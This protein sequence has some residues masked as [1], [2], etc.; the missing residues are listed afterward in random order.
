MSRAF[1]TAAVALAATL[2]VSPVAFSTSSSQWEVGEIFLGVGDLAFR[3][4]KGKYAV[5]RPDATPR[6]EFLTDRNRGY[7]GGCAV[8]PVDGTL[9][10]TSRDGNTITQFDAIGDQWGD[11]ALL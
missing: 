9:W 4:T 7:T 6:G 3:D 10:T 11:H 1:K 2:T 5:L 8:N